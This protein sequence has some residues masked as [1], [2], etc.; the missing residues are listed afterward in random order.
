MAQQYDVAG[1]LAEG[2]EA[3]AH[4][5]TYVSACHRLGYRHPDLTSYDGQLADCYD[6]EAGLDLRLL[7]TDCAA[8]SSLADAAD[9]ALGRQ[10]AQ[11][12][13]F[14]T[15][16]RGPGAEA[17]A[18]FLRRHC[19]AGAQLT[20][21]LR[22][23]ATGCAVLRDEL[24]R[25][26]DSKVA[27]VLA[28]DDGGGAQR[29]AWLAAAQ[30]VNSG[31]NDEHATEVIEKQ[32]IPY[33]DN[34]V[35]GVWASAVRPARDGAAAAYRS[36]TAAADVGAGVLF[37]IPGDLGPERPPDD[38]APVVPAAIAP[39]AADLPPA[40][41][42][43]VAG[44][45]PGA[46]APEPAAAVDDL[47]VDPGLPAGLGLPGDLGLPTGGLPTSGLGGLGGLGGLI[48]RLADALSDPG[49]GEPFNDAVEDT[50]AADGHDA[51]DPEAEPAD[52]DDTAAEV[53][54]EAELVNEAEPESEPTAAE[55]EPATEQAEPAV[56][57]G[58]TENEPTSEP[59]PQPIAD[60][61][62]KSPCEIAAQ[63][64]PQVGQ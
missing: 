3:L 12:A 26:V 11:L 20:A 6:S 35:R 25:L 28:L 63:E 40:D 54:A 41:A 59:A 30:A 15:A 17:A 13:E 46:A 64:L 47:P 2:R 36:A 39:V 7:D 53:P 32:V 4:N 21:R 50:S 37:A 51:D 27:A 33:V 49:L 24:W 55:P 14:A 16:W 9:D 22:A 45:R 48:P 23:S 1:R 5:Q 58:E 31:A 19:D 43:V 60:G 44:E 8:L 18:E 34:N 29:P 38:P 57:A 61:P 42:P 10:R 62:P 56:E 52:E